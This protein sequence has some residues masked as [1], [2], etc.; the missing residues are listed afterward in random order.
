[1]AKQSFFAER[2]ST[3]NN[4]NFFN[5]MSVEEIQKSVKR[6]IKD[7]KFDNI[8]E[9]DYHYFINN[10]VLTACIT[11]S[12]SQY[13]TAA[14]T[15]NALNYYIDKELKMGFNNIPGISDTLACASNEQMKQNLKYHIWGQIYNLFLS[16]QQGAEVISTLKNIQLMDFNVNIL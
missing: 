10:K 8:Q 16:I 14:V 6:I 1:M 5:H 11:E 2:R 7:I 3:N 13:K 4:P 12:Y 9:T 15:L